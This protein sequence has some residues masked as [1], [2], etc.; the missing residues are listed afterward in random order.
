MDNFDNA[1]EFI[2]STK[3][4]M[5]CVHTRQALKSQDFSTEYVVQHE[6][7]RARF[8]TTTVFLAITAYGY[9]Y[10]A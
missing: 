3:Y 5:I 9:R 10:I 4:S 2:D 6:M 7:V 1:I 8:L